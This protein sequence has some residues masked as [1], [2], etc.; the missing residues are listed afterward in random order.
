MRAA[1]P[2]RGMA[3]RFGML[4]GL[5]LMLALLAAGGGVRAAEWG[6]LLEPETLAELL[7]LDPEIRVVRV[8]GN[9]DEGHIPGSVVTEYADW[10]GPPENPGALPALSELEAEVRRLGIERDTPVVLVSEGAGPDDKGTATRIYWTLKSLGIERLA[11]LNGGFRGWQGAGLP[12]ETGSVSIAP[13]T[14]DATLS[15]SW[16]ITT[17]ELEARIAE[18]NA[19][20]RIDARPRE[21]FEGRT[22][23]AARPGTI[24]GAESLSHA[25]WFDEDGRID[26]ARV[27]EILARAGIGDAQEIVSFCN[28]G[29]WA[30]INWFVL[31]EIAEL[32]GTR[33]YAE[34]M[35]EWAAAGRPLDNAPSRLG[36]YWMVTRDWLGG[37]ADALGSPRSQG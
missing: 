8:S 29:H 12:V 15:D 2:E 18:G 11:V 4:A 35:A 22:W 19:P 6:P 27:P 36:Y 21:F 5:W 28:T 20:A 9:H 32:D 1:R 17:A 26:V 16:R 14:F 10:R 33:L 31:S 34:S 13:S 30:S 37:I 24:A 3:R 23:T 25:D 7:E